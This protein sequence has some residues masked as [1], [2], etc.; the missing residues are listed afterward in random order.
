[1]KPFRFLLAVICAVSLALALSSAVP[2]PAAHA[3]EHVPDGL[4]AA[5]WAQIQSLLAPE[6]VAGFNQQAKLTAGSDAAANDR[7]GYSVAVSGDTAVVGAHRDDDGGTD[8]GSA[9][10]FVRSGGSWSQQAKLTASDPA[11]SD[12]FGISVAVSGDTAVVGAL[13][14]DDGGFNSGSAYVFVRSG[15]IWNQ[16]AK[17]TAS[18]DAAIADE[19]GASVAVSGDT[20]IVGAHRNDDAGSASGSA[21]VFVR[22]GGIW[23]QQAKLTA[24]DAAAGDQFG[25]SVAVSGDTAVVGAYLDDH[26]GGIDS[27]SA[28]VF[29]RSG[30]IWSQQAKLTAS[31]AAAG[32][33]FGISVAVS[34]DTA[35]VGASWDDDGFTDNGS[36]YVFVR[37]GVS[38]SQQAKLTASD[39][40]AED[41]FGGSVAV[42]GDTAV[43]GAWLDD[44]VAINNGS[45]YVF[46]RS[47]VSWSEQAK[48][49]ASDA[50]A[51]DYFGYSVA[52]SGDTAVVGAYFDDDG[53][54]DSGS[55]YVFKRCIS[56]AQTG[57]WEDTATTWVG[58]V[59]PIGTDGVC[60]ENGHTVTMNGND[61]ID[62]LWVYA[63]GTLDISTHTLTVEKSVSN[64]GTLRQTRTVDGSGPV[65]FLQIRNIANNIDQYRGVDI[66]A[67]LNL[68]QTV[69]EVRGNTAVCNNNDGGAYR[70][71]CFMVNPTSPGMVDITLHS[72]AAEDDLTDDAFFQYMGGTWTPGTACADGIGVGGTCTGSATFA[73]PA[74]FLI[75]SG[76]NVPTAVTNLSTQTNT[77]NQNAYIPLLATLLT[78]VSGA[79][80]WLRRQTR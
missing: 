69:V 67:G 32:D 80:L 46:V 5:D 41:Y 21:Y 39:A 52:V 54:L 57:A 77:P 71:R 58:A 65:N 55:A 28:Y 74:W 23:N 53:G 47:G 63:G 7:F 35:V 22:S 4:T 20:A 33:L 45:A 31:D 66:A 78:L 64:E 29:V 76:G 68:G 2:L 50:A 49:T 14:D 40:A 10:V 19:F 6:A 27:G 59:A 34:G 62:Q 60:I 3:I 24:I 17:L 72:T 13:Y 25:Y 75:G 79:W 43:V 15:V 48:L 38:W 18:S 26:V 56:S 37:S 11:G 1:M 44:S 70:N 12:F 42:S 73:S 8:S 51:S 9:Y 30:G 61:A 16:Q 36:A